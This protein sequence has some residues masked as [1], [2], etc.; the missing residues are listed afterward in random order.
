[1]EHILKRIDW[2]VCHKLL[3]LIR[4]IIKILLLFTFFAQQFLHTTNQRVGAWQWTG[5]WGA[6]WMKNHFIPFVLLVFFVFLLLQFMH[7][8]LQFMYVGADLRIALDQERDLL[9]EAHGIGLN[10]AQIQVSAQKRIQV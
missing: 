4:I 1:M 5:A 10:I 8:L 7:L 2:S 6:I 3:I 9:V